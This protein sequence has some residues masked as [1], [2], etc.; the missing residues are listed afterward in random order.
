M[1][2]QKK[3]V[4]SLAA[5]C[6]VIWLVTAI[7]PLDRQAW[8]L[9]NILVVLFVLVLL[10]AYRRLQFST[11]AYV[12]IALFLV[13]HLIGAHYTYARMP[14]GLWAKDAFHLSR[15]HYD[16]FAHGAFGFFLALPL[17]E[18]LL[19][20][21]GVRRGAWSFWL[22]PAIILATSGFFEIVESVV[23]AIVAPGQ[24][25][26]WLGGQGDQWDAQNDM[27]SA[28]VGSVLMMGLATLVEIIIPHLSPRPKEE[29]GAQRQARRRS[30]RAE[31]SRSS[32]YFL[33]IALACYIVFWIA[34]AIHPVSR[35]DWFLENLLIF[36]SAIVLIATFHRFQFSN[37]S[38]ALLLIFLALH[39]IGAHYTYAKVPIGFWAADLFHLNRNHFDRVIHFGF[40]LLILY[41]LR[42]LLIRSAGAREAWA[43]WLAVAGIFAMSSFFEILEAVIAMLVHPELGDAYL[44]TQGDIWDAQKDMGAAFVGAL[45]T[46]IWL[47]IRRRS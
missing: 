3:T 16:R 17:R 43:T 33:P 44:G 41:P 22:P 31:K 29:A 12:C 8:I 39:T 34:L 40:G 46:A 32:R 10:P 30:Q 6:A 13:L 20:L 47:G 4:V 1:N 18:L 21:S 27:L 15:N 23:A 38:Y 14:L 37:L 11:A 36:V 7:H 2:T 26:N 9:E 24:G 19:R 35:S 5:I 45:L 25:V 42:E 28:F